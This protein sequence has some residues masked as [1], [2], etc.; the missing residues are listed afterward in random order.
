[1]KKLG[2][3]TMRLP[4]KNAS[5]PGSVDL[6]KTTEMFDYYLAE[7][8]S[9]FDTAFFYHNQ[10][11]ES[12]L[13][14]VL[15]KRHA[16]E[17]YVLTD[18][19]PIDYLHEKAD[20]E[21]IYNEQKKRLGI[22]YFDYYFMHAISRERFDIARDMGVLDFLEKK[23][24]AKE[25]RHIGF[26]FH[27][28]PEELEYILSQY[29][30]ELVQIQLNY[31]DWFDSGVEAA[32]LHSIARN[33]G[34]ELS[35]MEPLRGGSLADPPDEVRAALAAIVPGLSPA[36][37]GLRF[38][39]SQDGVKVV[40]SGMSSLEQV[41]ENTAFMKNFEPL[42]ADQLDK[43]SHLNTMLDSCTKIK[44]TACRYCVEGCPMNIA[45]PDYFSLYN[46]SEVFG[47]RMG[48]KNAY[49]KLAADHGKASDCISCGAC[50]SV[51]TQGLPVSALMAEVSARFDKK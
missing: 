45:I 42:T 37:A 29:K 43:I 47:L 23:K 27:G 39:A 3:G 12:V 26:S 49:A 30:T 32:R 10:K 14:E 16:R 50:E 6:Y 2:F 5:D 1:M 31:Y 40:L 46:K 44:C 21:R 7:G 41:I 35:I 28:R 48:Y 20:V 24:A 17:S 25:I 36:E 38:A 11:S 33:H 34:V 22:E 18:K 15:V 51:C 9:Y 13:G 8:F 4:L 19:L